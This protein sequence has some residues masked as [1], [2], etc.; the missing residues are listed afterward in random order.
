MLQI[1]RQ[2]LV[3]DHADFASTHPSPESRIAEI[4]AI[5]GPAAPVQEIR[6]RQIRFESALKQ[7]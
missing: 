4:Q 7:V 3:P 1:M 5:I 2:K 6:E